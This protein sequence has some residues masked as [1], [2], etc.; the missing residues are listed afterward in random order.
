MSRLS[1][2]LSVA[3]VSVLISATASAGEPEQPQADVSMMQ[4]LDASIRD[5][6][7]KR[8]QQDYAGAVRVLSQLM[9][10]APDDARVVGE[11]GKVLVQQGRPREAVDFLTRAVQLQPGDWTLY[12]ALGIAY[13][14]I[15][16][17]ADART[18]YDRALAIRPGEAVVFNNYAMSRMLAGDPSQAR[19][20]IGEAAAA[21]SD[22]RIAR[23]VKLI[24][25]V[26]AT[27]VA[28]A[29]APHPAP[30]AAPTKGTLP[31]NVAQ[32]PP[33]ALTAPSV[34]SSTPRVMMQA[35]PADPQAGSITRRKA[36]GVVA[37]KPA[38]HPSETAKVVKPPVNDGIPALRLA[39]DRP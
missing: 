34:A 10:V 39:N 5:A 20:L 29:A 17:F 7:V 28:T 18:A 32:H 4:S 23:N 24:N 38:P 37:A 15:N 1:A 2:L 27:A 22:E 13:D 25:S 6:Q 21:S 16:D 35:V 8:T 11:Y 30:T 33:R 3:A 14:Q 31:V 26:P 12:S 9:L 19:R 36:K